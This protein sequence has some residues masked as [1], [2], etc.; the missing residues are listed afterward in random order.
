MTG[1][2]IPFYSRGGARIS[3]DE[4]MMLATQTR[5]GPGHPGH[6][7][8]LVGLDR[9]GPIKVSTVWVGYDPHHGTG[10]PMV[11]ETLISAPN[12]ADHRCPYGTE[13]E[14]IEGHAEHVRQAQAV[15]AGMRAANDFLGALG[16]LLSRPDEES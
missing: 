12:Y 2:E 13:A 9:V 8:R 15:W 10:A 5:P 14:A 1:Y 6:V 4:W 3:A 16:D 11:F 7:Y